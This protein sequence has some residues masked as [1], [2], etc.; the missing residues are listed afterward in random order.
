MSAITKLIRVTA[1]RNAAEDYGALKFRALK[2]DIVALKAQLARDG[3][4]ATAF[5]EAVI[6][7]YNER[8]P[9]IL[10]MVSDWLKSEK[11]VGLKDKR[12]TA[13]LSQKDLNRLLDDIESADALDDLED[14][15]V[16]E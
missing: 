9:A 4:S 13:R 12:E 10:A 8:H 1:S 15:D 6:R 11:G 14:E 7:G 3:I 16:D 2:T 5:F